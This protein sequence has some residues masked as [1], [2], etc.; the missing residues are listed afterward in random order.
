MNTD[1]IIQWAQAKILFLEKLAADK[2]RIEM[3][4][5]AQR[6]LNHFQEHLLGF[7]AICKSY[8]VAKSLEKPIEAE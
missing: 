6:E 1:E 2:T 7:K 5:E 4:I 8:F 3:C